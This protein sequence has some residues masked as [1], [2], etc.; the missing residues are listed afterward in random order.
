MMIHMMI[1]AVKNDIK[2]NNMEN[3]ILLF[4][5]QSDMTYIRKLSMSYGYY[6]AL[7]IVNK[8]D[9]V[10][11]VGANNNFNIV[12]FRDLD[13]HYKNMLGKKRCKQLKGDDIMS[14]YQIVSSLKLVNPIKLSKP[15]RGM[16]YSMIDETSKLKDSI[17]SSLAIKYNISEDKVYNLEEF[18]EISKN[19]IP[20]D[21]TNMLV[22]IEGEDYGSF[23][24]IFD[25]KNAK[26]QTK[27]I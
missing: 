6:T 19:D 25:D 27:L 2:N 21:F 13:Y 8:K 11:H 24:D 22:N 12:P 15:C 17:I 10:T 16:R 1:S 23:L 14:V 5:P 20:L 26:G 4:K 18:Q 3:R 7:A 9:I